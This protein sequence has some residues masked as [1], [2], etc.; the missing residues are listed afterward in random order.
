MRG[1]LE[2][3]D[4]RVKVLLLADPQAAISAVKRAGKTGKARIADLAR[5]IELVAERRRRLRDARAVKLA[6]DKA[7]VGI[8][9]NEK[10]DEKSKEGASCLRYDGRATGGGLHLELVQKRKEEGERAAFG[11]G[12]EK[13]DIQA[14]KGA[15]KKGREVA[16]ESGV[17]QRIRAWRKEKREVEGER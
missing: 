12:N 16:T 1:A 5:V 10:A 4:G 3:V 7:P 2:A 9:G 6:W 14:K 8:E 15:V 11:R 17:H 13:V